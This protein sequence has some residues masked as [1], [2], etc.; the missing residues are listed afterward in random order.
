VGCKTLTQSVFL[1]LCSST[2]GESDVT[3]NKVKLSWN[4]GVMMAAGWN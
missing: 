3:D 2:F 1:L 4:A